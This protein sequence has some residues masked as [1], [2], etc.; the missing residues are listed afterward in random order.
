MEQQNNKDWHNGQKLCEILTFLKGWKT[1]IH[2]PCFWFQ[3]NKLSR[4]SPQWPWLNKIGLILL[5][6]N[7]PEA[8]AMSYLINLPSLLSQ[9]RHNII[10]FLVILWFIGRALCG[11]SFLP[12]E[13]DTLPD[14]KVFKVCRKGNFAKSATYINVQLVNLH[15]NSHRKHRL[16]GKLWN[17]NFVNK[18]WIFIFSWR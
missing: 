10:N 3:S 14:C 8:C 15:F 16:T 12:H 2:R 17:R 4:K 1:M 6:Q 18:R 9:V 5:E 7:F 11:V 13:K